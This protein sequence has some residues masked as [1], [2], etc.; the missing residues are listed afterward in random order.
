M[1]NHQ[2]RRGWRT[3]W[4]SPC[5]LWLSYRFLFPFLLDH[6]GEDFGSDLLLSVQQVAWLLALWYRVLHLLFCFLFLM[7]LYTATHGEKWGKDWHF[8]AGCPPPSVSF[9]FPHASLSCKTLKNGQKFEVS[10]LA[11]FHLL[12]RFLFLM[13][14][15][16]AKQEQKL[17]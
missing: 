2:N 11:V 12:L 8:L 13:N 7:H 15:Y 3:D 5:G 16:T 4:R 9:S 1:N 10:L 6:V 17:G 14:L